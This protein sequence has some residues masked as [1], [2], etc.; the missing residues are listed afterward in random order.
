MLNLSDRL[1]R[2]CTG[3]ELLGAVRWF[4]HHKC[5]YNNDTLPL[6]PVRTALSSLCVRCNL[7]AVA[8]DGNMKNEEMLCPFCL[9][10]SKEARQVQRQIRH[11]FCILGRTKHMPWNL[12][13]SSPVPAYKEIIQLEKEYFLFMLERHDLG[14]WLSELLLEHGEEY[15]AVLTL[16]PTT[17]K[18]YPSMGDSLRLAR[19]YTARIPLPVSGVSICLYAHSRHILRSPESEVALNS[20]LEEFLQYI[21]M[22][23]QF[24]RYIHPGD[25]EELQ[26]ILLEDRENLRFHYGRLLSRLQPEAREMLET[27]AVRQWTKE[28]VS[29][30]FSMLPF[31]RF[32]AP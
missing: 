19:H 13:Q 1:Y 17:G 24:R 2:C 12:Q 25:Q 15:Q 18:T 20:P 7:D 21:N 31:A 3:P 6:P 8:A 28:Q 30:F 16:F 23:V 9:A 14:P 26:Y 29:H 4:R 32:S 10:V 5:H 27:W 22:A 11:F